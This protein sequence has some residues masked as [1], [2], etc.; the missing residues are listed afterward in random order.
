MVRSHVIPLIVSVACLAQA[1]RASADAPRLLMERLKSVLSAQHVSGISNALGSVHPLNEAQFGDPSVTATERRGRWAVLIEGKEF[2]IS[3]RLNGTAEIATGWSCDI[4]RV[5]PETI[6]PFDGPDLKPIVIAKKKRRRPRRAR[7][8]KPRTANPEA[9]RGRSG[10]EG[11]PN[12]I[13]LRCAAGAHSPACR[14]H[15]A[16]ATRQ[17]PEVTQKLVGRHQ[18]LLG[19]LSRGMKSGPVNRKR[20]HHDRLVAETR[21]KGEEVFKKP[22]PP[23]T[24]W[25]NSDPRRERHTLVRPSERCFE[26]NAFG[27]AAKQPP[28]LSCLRDLMRYERVKRRGIYDSLAVAAAIVQLPIAQSGMENEVARANSLSVYRSVWVHAWLV[29]VQARPNR[30]DTALKALTVDERGLLQ[31]KLLAL[32]Q[33]PAGIKHRALITRIFEQRLTMLVPA[34]RKLD[35]TPDRDCFSSG[36]LWAL[37]W[38]W[39]F[40]GPKGNEATAAFRSLRREQKAELTALLDAPVTWLRRPELAKAVSAVRRLRGRTQPTPAVTAP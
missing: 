24:I 29:W 19:E 33:R 2:N 3:C 4:E 28:S 12:S 18:E 36:Y 14:E 6:E 27:P 9:G 23:V 5:T 39:V 31:E 40:A 37:N 32:W 15:W 1:P 35:G 25:L 10:P 11:A 16:S 13:A 26:R 7:T 21:G 34:C 22:P 20:L 38:L 17:A 8:T 30:L